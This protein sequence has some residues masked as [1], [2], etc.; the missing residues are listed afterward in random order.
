[1][2]G[3]TSAQSICIVDKH[4]RMMIVT[5]DILKATMGDNPKLKKLLKADDWGLAV[6]IEEK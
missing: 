5:G 2:V 3:L 1:M 6:R 4:N